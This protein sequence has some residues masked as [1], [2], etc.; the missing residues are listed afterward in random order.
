M[1]DSKIRSWTKSITWRILGIII[2]ACITYYLTLDLK[3]TT[4][5]TIIFHSIRLV[6]YYVHERTWEHISWGRIRNE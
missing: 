6:L 4:W 2:L 5:I 3:Q 1:I